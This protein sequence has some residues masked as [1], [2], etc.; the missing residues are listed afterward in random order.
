MELQLVSF[1]QAK[2][3]KSLGFDWQ[4]TGYYKIDGNGMFY[5]DRENYNEREE[6]YSRPTVALALMWLREVKGIHMYV[7]MEPSSPLHYYTFY[8]QKLVS[9]NII[10]AQ[11]DLYRYGTHDLAESAARTKALTLLTPQS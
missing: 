2:L 7:I 3:L 9:E 6:Y 4:C 11:R 10:N 1:E 8:G 5:S